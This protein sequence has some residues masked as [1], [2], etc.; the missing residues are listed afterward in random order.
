[1]PLPHGY[2]TV[3]A[4]EDADIGENGEIFIRSLPEFKGQLVNEAGCNI[5]KGE[6][7]LSAG[8]FIRPAHVGLLASGGIAELSVYARPTVAV[9]PTGSELIFPSSH[10]PAGKNIDSNSY[11]IAAYLTGWGAVPYIFPI[12][13]D[14]PEILTDNIRKAVSDFDAVIVIAG[15]SLGTK[16]Y[17]Q[18]LLREMGTVLVPELAHG[19]GR[20]CSFSVVDE[21]PVLG[22]PG[23]PLGAQIVCDLYLSPFVS[24]LLGLPSKNLSPLEVICDDE[25]REYDVDFCERVHIYKNGSKYHIRSAFAPVTTRAEMQALSNGNFYRKAHT[26]C[27]PGDRTEVELLCPAE[28]IPGRDLLEEILDQPLL[29]GENVPGKEGGNE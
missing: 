28:W 1:M 7:L 9:I 2:D 29:C 12:L 26:S 11:M 16:D 24:F 22:I 19:P 18:K 5:K 8:E 20:K 23:P 15:S 13:P 21:K 14:E 6:R 27:R 17:T 4:I 10:V 3:I 25:F